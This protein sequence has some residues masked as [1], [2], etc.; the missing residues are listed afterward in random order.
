MQTNQ[1]KARLKIN[2]SDGTYTYSTLSLKRK[3]G[4]SSAVL[5]G[6]V[7]AFEGVARITYAPT[8]YNEFEFSSKEDFVDKIGPCMERELYAEFQAL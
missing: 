8:Y 3:I 6:K 7:G 4:L 1:L 5:K 2:F